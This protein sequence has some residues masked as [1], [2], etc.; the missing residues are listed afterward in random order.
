[1]EVSRGQSYE[2][3]LSALPCPVIALSASVGNPHMLHGWIKDIQE[4][5]GQPMADLVLHTRRWA[6]LD[7][8]MYRPAVR[9]PA[10]RHGDP[11][12]QL[13]TPLERRGGGGAECEQ[14]FVRVHPLALYGT[15]TG[16]C[17]R[18]TA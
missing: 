10:I 3:I 17:S 5:K 14:N 13:G 15:T 7:L 2:H 11:A 12:W 4:R 8:H 1:M 18:T 9:A 6:D 16:M